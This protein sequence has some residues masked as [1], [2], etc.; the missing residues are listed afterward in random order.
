M[1]KNIKNNDTKS[2]PNVS[3]NWY[4]G[5]MAKTK[6][7]I[8][9]D[10]KL[11]DI[12]VEILDARIPISSQN[13]SMK[14]II[15]NKKRIVILNKSDLA[16]EKQNVLW[17]QYFEKQNI[18]T[19]ITESNSGKGINQFVKTVEE[20]MEEEILENKQKGRVGKVIRLLVLG[21]PNVGKS[22]FINRVSKRTTMEVGNKPG[23]TKKKQW[24]HVGDHIELLDTPGVLWPK[25]ES[26]EVALNLAYTGTIK[27][28]ILERTE[29]AFYLLKFLIKNYPE[30]LELRYKLEK[31]IMNE[32]LEDKDNNE[33]ILELVYLIGRKRGA[34]ISGGNIDEEKTANL[35]LEDFR[36]GKLGRITIEKINE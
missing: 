16:D 1:E 3:I 20:Y 10:L 23:V 12:V 6:K 28:D 9:E 4:P 8:I 18:P 11:I 34:I 29:I 35:L 2:F 24:I 14:E 27:D 17:K 30:A 31:E 36:S 13:P 33:T 5:H 7:Q 22:S 26:E 19:V 25:F 15:K 21:I 32:I